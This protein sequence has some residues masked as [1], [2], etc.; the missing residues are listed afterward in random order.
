VLKLT[1]AEFL[2]GSGFVRAIPGPIFSIASYTGAVALKEKGIR[3]QV[4]GA[5]IASIGVFLP[6]FLIVLFFF[7]LW[8][9]L[10]KF[11]IFFRSL[12]GI[13]ASI[14]GIMIGSTFYLFKDVVLQLQVGDTINWI[15]FPIVFL[16]STYLLYCQ[17]LAPQWIALGCVCMG[18]VV[19]LL[20]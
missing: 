17:K 1:S 14:V 3:G 9:K 4:L 2:T 15:T 20:F 5:V 10:Q 12:E 6:S 18:T 11:A 8:Q 13:Y 16:A 7:P 19:Y